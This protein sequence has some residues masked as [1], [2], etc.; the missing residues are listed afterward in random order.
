MSNSFKEHLP[1]HL[2]VIAA[3]IIFGLNFVIAKG[4]MPNW[5]EPRAVIFLRVVG[6]GLRVKSSASEY[7]AMIKSIPD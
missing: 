1:A 3:N 2:A 4:I 7:A 6:A 5:L